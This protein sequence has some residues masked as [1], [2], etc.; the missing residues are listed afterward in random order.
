MRRVDGDKSY[1]G[2]FAA[3][4]F[5][6][7][8]GGNFVSSGDVRR[9]LPAR[10]FGFRAN[11]PR[12]QGLR[13]DNRKLLRGQPAE[14][15]GERL[16]DLRVADLIGRRMRNERSEYRRGWASPMSPHSDSTPSFTP[17]SSR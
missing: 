15:D 16:D 12:V 10:R 1:D 17:A 5:P 3:L 7:Y 6:P 4:I 11:A 13:R 2:E 8:A 9:G 14:L